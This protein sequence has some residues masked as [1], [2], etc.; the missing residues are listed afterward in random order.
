[1]ILGVLSEDGKSFILLQ[2]PE[3]TSSGELVR[4]CRSEKCTL[5]HPTMMLFKYC[6]DVEVG[7]VTKRSVKLVPNT[8]EHVEEELEYLDPDELGG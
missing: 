3:F 1:M 2:H 5:R 8:V 7:L 6:G 4:W